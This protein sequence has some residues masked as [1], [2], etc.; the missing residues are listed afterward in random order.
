MHIGAGLTRA[1]PPQVAQRARAPPRASS[2]LNLSRSR[3][4]VPGVVPSG[5]RRQRRRRARWPHAPP[6]PW[7]CTWV[8][9]LRH[10]V[11]RAR[12]KGS[13]STTRASS[14]QGEC[15]R[16]VLGTLEET[17]RRPTWYILFYQS[18]VW[19]RATC[20]HLAGYLGQVDSPVAREGGLR[21]RTPKTR[22]P[23]SD[24]TSGKCARDEALLTKGTGPRRPCSSRCSPLRRRHRPPERAPGPVHR[25]AAGPARKTR[26][27]AQIRHC[28]GRQFCYRQAGGRLGAEGDTALMASRHE[29]RP[30]IAARS[31]LTA[32]SAACPPGCRRAVSL[33]SQCFPSFLVARLED[34]GVQR[35]REG[36]TARPPPAAGPPNPLRE[37]RH[38]DGAFAAAEVLAW[39]DGGGEIAI[40][41]ATNSSRRRQKPSTTS[42]KGVQVVFIESIVRRR[43][44]SFR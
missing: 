39:F 15:D 2:T 34:Q 27:S 30:D 20:K 19:T 3:S 40:F 11:P 26:A 44:C 21:H 5:E 28:Q 25:V 13:S 31:E 33:L 9:Q 10:Y 8:A 35:W 42:P 38:R 6:S 23:K 24:V 4:R 1:R 36:A 37:R 43:R 22:D 32:D 17:G 16:A 7:W 14:H 41:D 29:K 12:N 18:D